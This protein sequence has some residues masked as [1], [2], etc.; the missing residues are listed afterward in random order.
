MR[1]ELS[2]LV[3]VKKGWWRITEADGGVLGVVRGVDEAEA[4]QRAAG[5]YGRMSGS[6]NATCTMPTVFGPRTEEGEPIA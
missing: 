5:R 6:L 2:G 3:A 1:N 4:L